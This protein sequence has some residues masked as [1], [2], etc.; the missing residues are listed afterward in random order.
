MYNFS[1]SNNKLGKIISFLNP[2]LVAFKMDSFS[3]FN[4]NQ[5]TIKVMMQEAMTNI[6]TQQM[7]LMIEIADG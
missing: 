6:K 5:I 4:D 1:T 3:L 7:L 2:F